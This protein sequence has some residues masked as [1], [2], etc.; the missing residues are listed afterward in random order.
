MECTS[1]VRQGSTDGLT[2]ALLKVSDHAHFVLL[3]AT[4]CLQRCPSAL[5]P[6]LGC[7]VGGTALSSTLLSDARLPLLAATPE[8]EALGVAVLLRSLLPLAAEVGT[9]GVLALPLGVCMGG[10]P[11][12][13]VLLGVVL[14]LALAAACMTAGRQLYICLAQRER[15]LKHL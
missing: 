15:W 5:K 10:L 7:C 3:P 1:L 9:P 13:A 4:T 11:D 8:V 6:Y 14:P 2:A 12:F